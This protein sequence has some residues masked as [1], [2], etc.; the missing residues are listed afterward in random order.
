MTLLVLL[1][2]IGGQAIAIDATRVDTV[3]AVDS[4]VPVPFA[5]PHIVGIAAIRSQT[6]TVID[7][8]IATGGPPL[9]PSGRAAICTVDGHRYALRLEAIDDV[10]PHEVDRSGFDQAT[11]SVWGRIAQGRIELGG[12]FAVLIDPAL[13][14]DARAPV[15]A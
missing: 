12:Q 13:L 4:V 9:S 15:S 14:I 3:A 10:V 5:P 7:T 11:S 1:G 8:S 6:V 2:R